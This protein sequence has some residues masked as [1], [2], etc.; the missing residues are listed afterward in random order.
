MSETFE[1][2]GRSQ[3]DGGAER[4]NSELNAQGPCRGVDLLGD[5]WQVGFREKPAGPL[6]PGPKICGQRRPTRWEEE[7]DLTMT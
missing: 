5:G 4:E 3:P 1:N 2:L 6:I 7:T